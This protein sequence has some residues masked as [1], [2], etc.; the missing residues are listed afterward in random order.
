LTLAHLLDANVTIHLRD[1]D[2]TVALQVAALG[3][4]ILLV[5]RAT[6]V[7]LNASDLRDVPGLEFLS[8]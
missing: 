4:A 6:L 8:W 1:G 2:E 5:H 3:G 7:A